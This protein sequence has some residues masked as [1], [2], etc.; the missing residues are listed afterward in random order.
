MD[1]DEFLGFVSTSDDF[2]LLTVQAKSAAPSPT[3][4][5]ITKFNAIN[6]FITAN[7]RE[8]DAA[9][10]DVIEFQLHQR[11]SS[12]RKNPEHCI[13]LS[14]VDIHGLLSPIKPPQTS[15]NEDPKELNSLDDI[16]LDDTMGL[17]DDDAESIYVIKH[18]PQSRLSP[19]HVSRRKKCSDFEKFKPIFDKHHVG[20]KSGSLKRRKFQSELQIQAGEVFVIDGVLVYVANIGDKEKKGFGNVNARLYCVFDNG[21]ESN[22]YLRSLAAAMWKDEASGQIVDANQSDIFDNSSPITSDDAASGHIYILKSL[23]EDPKIESINDLYKI[24]YSTMPVEKRI[25]NAS[26]D[27]TYLMGPVHCVAS[28]ECFN[29]NVQKFELL[30]HTFFGKACLDIDITGLDKKTHRPREWFIVPFRII[31]TV[32]PLLINGE[33]INYQYDVGAREIVKKEWE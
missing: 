20:L 18:V 2:E 28:Y 16:F 9:N 17:L 7:G 13:Q 12:L 30:L 19:E 31:E 8:P 15:N 11:L 5:L 27:P 32:I 29:L 10:Q 6:D 25:A 21:T 4:Y 24:G 26:T 22:M 14:E 3:D 23:S 1:L 33:I